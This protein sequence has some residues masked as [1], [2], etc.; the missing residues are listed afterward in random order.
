MTRYIFNVNYTAQDCGSPNA[1]TFAC[2]M[3]GVAAAMTKTF[4]NS[5]VIANGTSISN[6]FLVSGNSSL[7]SGRADAVATFVHVQWHW[8]LLPCTVWGLGVIT[9]VVVAFHTRRLRLPTWRDS[10]LPLL[11]LY[12][13]GD[14]RPSEK[15]YA[16]PRNP[17]HEEF[18]STDDYSTWAHEKVAGRINVQLGKVPSH[19]GGMM[20][21]VPM[22]KES[23]VLSP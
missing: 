7:V 2:A 20:R 10:P 17:L 3:V 6:A 9:W 18:L 21:L 23:P 12:R 15:G 1:D 19:S 22:E 13:E 5:G 14:D 16:S 8:I 4:R 11:F